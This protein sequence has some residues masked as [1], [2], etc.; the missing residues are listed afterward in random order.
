MFSM[1]L[2]NRFQARVKEELE[3]RDWSQSKLAESMGV[4]RA[5]VSNYLNGRS[6]PGLDVI[7]RFAFALNVDPTELLLEPAHVA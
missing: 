3:K 6:S 1:I 2:Q 4:G 5:Y 7:E